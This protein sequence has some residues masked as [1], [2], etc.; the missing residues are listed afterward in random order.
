MTS[1]ADHPQT[2]RSARRRRLAITLA[3]VGTA[4]TLLASEALDPVGDGTADN[5][6]A[7]ATLVIL[8]HL[9]DLKAELEAGSI[10]AF[11]R[12]RLRIRPLPI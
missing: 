11:G 1:I 9:P 12:D 3:T 7:A 2:S 10:V 6:L 8:D 5:F 4:L